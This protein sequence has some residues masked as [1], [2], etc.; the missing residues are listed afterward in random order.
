VQSVPVAL[1]H[2]VDTTLHVV[3]HGCHALAG[4]LGFAG[5]ARV[6][7]TESNAI[8]PTVVHDGAGGGLWCLIVNHGG[9]KGG[10]GCGVKAHVKGWW[11]ALQQH[12][13]AG[14]WLVHW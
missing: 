2:G 3:N 8:H 4:F 1:N 12:W 6:V 11:V 5:G 9:C 10:M 14:I 13:C 7:G